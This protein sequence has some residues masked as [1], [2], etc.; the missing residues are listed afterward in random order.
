MEQYFDKLNSSFSKLSVLIYC[1][2]KGEILSLY[3]SKNKKFFA[4]L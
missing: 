4:T 1:S 3:L 2:K